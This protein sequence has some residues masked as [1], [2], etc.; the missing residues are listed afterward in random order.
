MPQVKRRAELSIVG[1]V[2]VLIAIPYFLI[3]ALAFWGVA[4]WL[5]VGW[6]LILLFLFFFGG[7]FLAATE[8]RRI[9]VRASQGKT[10]PGTL[11]GDYGLLAA[12]ALCVALPGFV[13]TILG[14]LLIIPPT[15]SVARRILARKIRTSIEN[16]GARSFDTVN[17]FRQQTSYGSFV[18]DQEPEDRQPT[19]QEIQRWSNNVRPEDFGTNSKDA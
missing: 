16:L 1:T 12:S 5:G 6:A 13:T 17:Q 8:M 3:E 9:A 18:S 2:P 11:A 15:R 10:T 4:R 19:D 14:L 7:L